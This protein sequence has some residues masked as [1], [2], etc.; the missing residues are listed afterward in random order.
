MG[1][2]STKLTIQDDRPTALAI[3]AHNT[4]INTIGFNIVFLASRSPRLA[5][6]VMKLYALA[7]KV[8]ENDP[9]VPEEDV[10]MFAEEVSR[11]ADN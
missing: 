4:H 8:Q 11:M 1:T 7:Q 10:A 2:H 5:V 6:D 9:Q 3:A